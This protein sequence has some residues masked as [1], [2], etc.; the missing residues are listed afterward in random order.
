M[1]SLT[2]SSTNRLPI[3]DNPVD[4]YPWGE[5]AFQ[6]AKAEDKPVFLSV[7]YST[8]RWCHVMERESFENE[9]VAKMM[10]DVCVNVKVDREVLP[11]VDRVYMNYV[12]AIS[13][14]G[15]WPMSVWITPDTKIPFFGGTYFPPQAMEQI[16]TQVKDKWKNERDKLVPKGNSLSD[17]LQEPASPTSPALSQL[18][19]PLL[20]DRGL[21]MLGQM[22]DRTHGG[23]GGA[24]K[25]PTQSRFSFLH[26]VAYLAEDSNNLGRKMSAFTL[27]KMAMGGIHDQI[28]LGFHRYSVDAAWHIPHFEIMLYDN[29]QLA[30]HYLTYYVLTG[31]EYYRTVANG[32]LAYLDRVLLKKTD[33]GIAYMSAEDAESYE[34]EGDTIKKEGAFYVWTRAQITA[35]LGE[36]DGDAFCDHFGVKEEG[37]V[38]LEHDPHKELQGKNVLMEQRSAEETATALGISTEEMEG[39]INRGREVLREERDKRPKPHLDDK[40][41]ASW[42]GLMLKTLAQAALRLPSGPEPEKFY[43]QGIEVARFVQNQMIKDGKLLRCYRTNVQGVCEDYA[44]VINGLLALYQVKLEPWLL[45]IAVELQDKQDELFWD[46]KAWG[47][48]A[49]AEDSDASKIMRLKDDH[50]GPEPSANSLSLHNLVTLDSICHATDPFALGIPNMSES[51]AERYQMY[52]Q[53]MVTFFTPRLLTQPA[54]MPEMVSA[55]MIYLKEPMCVIISA[56]E[57]R[58]AEVFLAKIREVDEKKWRPD[59]IYVWERAQKEGVT[60]RVCAGKTCGLPSGDPQ[61]VVTELGNV[62]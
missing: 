34:E 8:C 3:S 37:N 27:K 39:I 28:G 43:N 25:F 38:G 40:I 35:A 49:S 2:G 10:N 32:V 22:Y 41:I 13:G 46:E 50:D 26:L 12:T 5:E 31:D 61:H 58:Q 59:T 55:A 23:F 1:A 54:S 47:Y 62:H 19:L 24:P 45:R 21:A 15:G 20:R 6:K 36:K 52:A 7:G 57:Q 44:S 4:W 53:K 60:G 48:F 29:A 56:P 11:D 51:R 17:I 9:E 30:Y 18:G 42:N 16:L 33:H 14:R